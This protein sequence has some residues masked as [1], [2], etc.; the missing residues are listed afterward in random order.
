MAINV[1]SGLMG[2]GK[3][4]ECV[5][6]V[7][8]PAVAAGRRVV[9]NIEGIQPEE[10]IAYCVEKLGCDRSSCGSVVS[11]SSEDVAKPDFL[12]F[13]NSSVPT[14]VLPGDLV[15]IDEAWNYWGTDCKLHPNHLE[16][17]HMHR[18]Y[19]DAA[20]GVSCDL[21]MMVQDISVLHRRLKS[22]VELS[23]RCKKLKA[24]GLNKAYCIQMW[25]GSRQSPK[26]VLKT[27]NKKYDPEFFPL[28]SSYTASSGAKGKE[29][30]VDKRQNVLRSPVLWLLIGGTLL[31]AVV[32]VSFLVHS[33]SSHK[34]VPAQ[35]HAASVVPLAAPAGGVLSPSVPVSASPRAASASLSKRWRLAGFIRTASRN[36]VVLADPTGRMRYE[37]Q[38]RFS[39][40]GGEP[41][42]ALIDGEQV[43]P[44]SGSLPASPAL[45][46][47]SSPSLSS[48]PAPPM[49]GR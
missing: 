41:Y 47:D 49:M 45:P 2:S 46:S 22:V 42:S 36:V 24:F 13:G 18:H 15:C 32:S 23:F 20:T 4:Y 33:F 7:I 9:T 8:V 27:E 10:V 34:K 5:S 11:V 31:S 30:T 14:V 28:Y 48:L 43:T 40:F 1:Y 19:V 29:V 26:S 44:F 39:F 25:E 16:F 21:V 6:S 35:P 37:D 3:S 12:Y 38:S 17:F